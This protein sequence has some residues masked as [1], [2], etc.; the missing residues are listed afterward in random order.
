MINTIIFDLDDT[1]YPE[2]EFVLSGLNAVSKYLSHLT[3][4]NSVKLNNEL[5]TLHQESS[6]NVFDRFLKK[7]Q[8]TALS[9][10]NII[11]FYR[12]HE[13][14]LSLKKDVKHILKHLKYNYNLAIITDG[15]H[16]KQMNKVK[17][18]KLDQLIEYI[19]YTSKL[20]F[21]KGKPHPEAFQ[22]VKKYFGSQWD[23]MIYIGDNP[24]KDFHIKSKFPI[25][26]VRI[27]IGGYYSNKKYLDDIKEDV[28]IHEL[29][30]I[31]KII[32]F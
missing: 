22:M 9:K 2:Q 15:I 4:I 10:E 7:H 17:A 8:L 29:T 19:V 28:L 13:P 24:M 21:D 23:E 1:L 14:K 16:K 25:K 26:T 27:N 20:G 5:I 11:R 31:T 18:L 6:Q 30:E 12:E 3:G 32:K